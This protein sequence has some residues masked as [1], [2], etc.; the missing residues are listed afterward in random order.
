MSGTYMAAEVASQPDCWREA[1]TLA[2]SVAGLLPEPGAR[3]AIAGCG[4]SWFIGQAYAV[5]REQAGHGAT[6]AFA[7]S[8]FP[9]GRRYDHVIA[10]TR[11]GT[12]TEVRSLLAKMRGVSSTTV[13]TGVPAEVDGT[14]DAVIDLS[15]ADERSVVQTRFATSTLALL[16]THLGEDIEPVAKQAEQVLAE[17]LAPELLSA[18]QFSFL[19]TGWSVGLAHEAALKFREACLFWSESYPAWDYRHGPISIAEPGRVTWM[20]GTAPDGLADDV[21]RTGGTFVESGLDPLADLV[22]AQRV[23]GAIAANKGLDPDRPRS[24]TRSVVLT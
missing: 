19:G 5:L 22:R 23:A 17:P 16:R 7:A 2:G 11:S 3:V 13:I 12:T 4:T 24:L 8:E 1:A 10:L 14:A 6:D 15:S 21:R 9:L 18:E 20:F